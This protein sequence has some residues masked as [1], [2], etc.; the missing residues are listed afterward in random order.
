MCFVL[1][2][3]MYDKAEEVM[4]RGIT[5]IPEGALLHSSLGVLLGKQNRLEVSY[6][7]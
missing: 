1:S 6:R 7:P 4:K 5:E 2:T 3:D